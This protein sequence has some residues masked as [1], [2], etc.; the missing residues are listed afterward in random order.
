VVSAYLRT[1]K[2]VSYQLDNWLE[3]RRN[4]SA[5]YV[6]YTNCVRAIVGK[7]PFRKR[8][9]SMAV[10]DEIPTVSDE[11]LTLLGIEN[12]YEVW[13]DVYKNLNGDIRSVRN[14][15]AVPD[16]WKSSIIP[17]YTMTTQTNP[18]A[19][20]RNTNDKCWSTEG[21]LRFNALR[22]LVIQDRADH[23]YFKIK[24]LNQV[25]ADMKGNLDTDVDDVGDLTQVEADDDLFPETAAAQPV[26]NPAKQ[27][28]GVSDAVYSDSNDDGGDSS[29]GS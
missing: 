22:L 29:Q 4:Y 2:E 15:E 26:L 14:D 25:R 1:S 28:L 27:K 21:I 18:G 12:S 24:W 19:I 23:P 16:H 20:P 8:L 10:G 3:M 17:K 13:N 9:G 5:Y 7:R 11:A 6:F